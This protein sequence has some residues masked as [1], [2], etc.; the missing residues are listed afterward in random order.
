MRLQYISRLSKNVLT[1]SALA[2]L[3]TAPAFAE[4]D[5]KIR[6]RAQ[7]YILDNAGLSPQMLEMRRRL[8]ERLAKYKR[9]GACEKATQS[10]EKSPETK[11]AINDQHK[12]VY[13]THVEFND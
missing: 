4:R 8:L 2:L 13:I 10:V 3:M 5:C 1:T 9:G 12:W 6:V 11:Q 7:Q